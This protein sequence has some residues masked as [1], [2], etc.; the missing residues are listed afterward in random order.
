MAGQ[1]ILIVVLL[2]ATAATAAWFLLPVQ[3]AALAL[4]A[5][6]RRCGL[7]LRHLRI[8][9]YDIAYLD[10]G[11][12]DDARETLVLLHG[13]GADKD[14]FTRSAGVLRQRFRVIA[15]DLPGFG[16]S[17][18]PADG[19]YGIHDQVEHV[20]RFLKQLGLEKVHLGGNSMGGC[21]AAHLAAA[22][23]QLVDSLWLLAPAGVVGAQDSDMMRRLNGGELPPLFAHTPADFDAVLAYVVHRKPFVPGVLLRVLGRRAAA[24]Y[25]LHLRIFGQLFEG[26]HALESVASRI[27]APTLVVWGAEDRVLDSSGAAVLRDAIAGAEA[28]VMP[29]IGHLPMMESVN[30][31]AR[32]WLDF[33]ARRCG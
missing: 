1:M 33:V 30:G 26:G 4:A 6:R 13:I 24:N 2:L 14:H 21:I 17:S 9:D 19:R 18:K 27:T 31:S 11:A 15:P 20:L 28:I 32:A 12:T 10:G 25:V 29:G 8:P 16:D 22:H 7:H 23:P 5:E 3:V